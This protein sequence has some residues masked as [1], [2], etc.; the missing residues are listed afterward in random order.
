LDALW[1]VLGCPRGSKLFGLGDIMKMT[2]LLKSTAL[3]L[4]A[5]GM[6]SAQVA[7]AAAPAVKSAPAAEKIVVGDVSLDNDGVLAGQVVDAQ[8]IA[9]KGVPVRVVYQGT[10]IAA[11]Q[12]DA[13]G[14][15]A[16]AG[17]REGVHQVE[18]P[19]S[20]KIYR[21]WTGHTSPKSASQGVL[22]V[23]DGTV[24][25]GNDCGCNDCSNWCRK[26]GALF[27]LGGAATG[28]VLIPVL[29]SGS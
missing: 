2:R 17:L 25:R 14:R 1:I 28:A 26:A 21:I 7:T 3:I 6:L 18:T 29:G 15:F 10:Q 16:I 12:S 24:E 11:V 5:V 27:L 20:S 13:E 8:G 9:L 23:N 22:L 19:V 4:A